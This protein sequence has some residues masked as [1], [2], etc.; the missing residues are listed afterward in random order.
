M[1]T[2]ELKIRDGWFEH[3]DENARI[4]TVAR[5]RIKGLGVRIRFNVDCAVPLVKVDAVELVNADSL[6][7]LATGMTR[8]FDIGPRDPRRGQ[9]Y[10]TDAVVELFGVTTVV[11]LEHGVYWASCKS[12]KNGWG[13]PRIGFRAAASVRYQSRTRY[14]TRTYLTTGKY[15][16]V[17]KDPAFVS[18]VRPRLTSVF[19]PLPEYRQRGL[20]ALHSIRLA[21][22][23][24]PAA[25]RRHFTREPSHH[26][27]RRRRRGVNSTERRTDGANWETGQTGRAAPWKSDCRKV[28][29]RLKA[30][31]Y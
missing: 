1:P 25:G 26:A 3:R 17:G 20:I 22:P 14:Y 9:T 4:P 13:V 23:D 21:E 10:T 18:R 24:L 2:N 5:E 6:R 28:A 30:R 11:L 16:P 7:P 29:L 8:T 27:W 12:P 19:P 31:Y 15:G